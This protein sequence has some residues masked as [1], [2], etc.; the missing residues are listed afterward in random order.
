[1]TKTRLSEITLEAARRGAVASAPWKTQSEVRSGLMLRRRGVMHKLQRD[2]QNECPGAMVERLRAAL[3]D[4]P[5]TLGS[6]HGGAVALYFAKDDVLCCLSDEDVSLMTPD[7]ALLERLTEVLPPVWQKD[8]IH[9]LI[10]GLDGPELTYAGR[11]GASFQPENYEPDVADTLEAVFAWA[12]APKPY[13]RIV[14]LRGPPGT[15][16]SY[17]GRAMITETNGVEWVYVPPTSVVSL[18]RPDMIDILI[19]GRQTTGPLGLLVEDADALL[20]LRTGDNDNMVAQLL[21]LGD[22]IPAEIADLRIVLTTN[23]ER[24][25]ID[26]AILRQ[27]RL[28][29][30]IE[31]GKLSPERAAAV[32]RRESGGK[33]RE[34]NEDMNLADVYGLA[35]EHTTG[36]KERKPSMGVYV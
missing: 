24:L 33:E 35:H 27:G 17:A 3:N 7:A 22:G 25:E 15:G 9:V 11:V 18:T 23:V 8:S 14:I 1:M 36:V 29:K 10:S 12:E 4:E 20:R 28:F 21:N 19:R 2:L 26:K 34:F 30:M 32:Y 16:K 31:F 6:F 13:G 5:H